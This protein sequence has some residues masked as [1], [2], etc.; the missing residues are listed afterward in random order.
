MQGWLGKR[1]EKRGE[2]EDKK[3]R[4]KERGSCGEEVGRL[5][6]THFAHQIPQAWHRHHDHHTT[7]RTRRTTRI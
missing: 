2:M 1:N 5:N 4:G 3:E 6:E 7:T